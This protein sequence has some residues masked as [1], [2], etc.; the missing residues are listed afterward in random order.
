MKHIILLILLPI[1]S[2][3]QEIPKKK[4]IGKPQCFECALT[5]SQMK[6]NRKEKLFSKFVTYTTSYHIT[7][8]KPSRIPK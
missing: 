5:E 7:S 8:W 4:T 6:E 3:S 2:Y 1:F